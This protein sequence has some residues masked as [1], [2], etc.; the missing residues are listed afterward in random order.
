MNLVERVKA[1][2]LN[3]RA[4]WPVI[5]RE[6]G[7]PSYLFANY[8]AILAAIPAVAMFIGYSFS[9]FGIGHAL[10]LAI[11]SYLVSCGAWYVGALIVDGLAPTF[12]GVKNFQQALKLSAYS[13]TAVWLAGIFNLIPP[14]S[15]LA[16]LGLYSIYLLWLGLPPLM[17]C[18][19]EKATPYTAAVFAIVFVLLIIITVIL[20]RIVM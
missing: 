4:E 12:G 13:S 1:I 2:L 16:I 6:T 20:G 19:Q 3:P 17:K 9:G 7:E 14:L 8:V 11:F 15:F 5:E 10:I 18:P